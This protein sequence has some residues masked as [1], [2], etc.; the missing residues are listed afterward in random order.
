MVLLSLFLTQSTADN[1]RFRLVVL[2]ARDGIPG[3]NLAE[4]APTRTKEKQANLPTYPPN[5]TSRPKYTLKKVKPKKRGKDL[6]G[7][8]SRG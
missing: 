4:T 8:P 1:P 5:W 3:D 2:V 6:L 7:I